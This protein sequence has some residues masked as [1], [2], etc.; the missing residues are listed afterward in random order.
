MGRRIVLNSTD[1]QTKKF[2]VDVGDTCVETTYVDYANKHIVCFS[3]MAGCPVGCQFCVSGQNDTYRSLT[4]EEMLLQCHEALAD[5]DITS[6][7]ILFSCMGEGEPFLNYA[8]V[9]ATFK[10]LANMYPNSKLAM[11]TS[12][13]KPYLLKDLAQEEFP[14]PFKL[15]ISIHSTYEHIRQ[16]LMPHAGRAA[17]IKQYVPFYLESGKELEYNYVLL[18]G[19]NDHVTDATR[20][21]DFANGVTIKLNMLN[22]VPGSQFKFSTNFDRFCDVL[23]EKGANYEFYK[24]NGTDI[25]AACGQLSHKAKG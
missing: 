17:G 20:L 3:S 14:V 6:K 22:A 11:S 5:V 18:D 7:L 2:L 1:K 10:V 25:N 9:I 15:Q 19:I 13:V 4:T 24:T 12:G 21:A 23:D 8:N 16:K